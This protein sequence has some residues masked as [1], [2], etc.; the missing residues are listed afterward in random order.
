MEFV[1]TPYQPGETIAAI[2]TPPG[3]GGIAIIRISGDEALEIADKVFTG[4]V[5]TYKTH[6]AHLGKVI[7]SNGDTIDEALA[8]VMLGKRSFCGEDTVEI[9]CHGG[10]IVS[11]HVL[12]VTIQA[13]ARAARPGEFSFKA[14]INGKIDLSQAE[15]IQE[16]ISAKNDMAL[17]AA[18]NH[19][20]GKLSKKVA[21]FQSNL[22]DIAAML[23]AW[24]DFPEE[25]IAF[26][27]M[28][29][30]RNDLT[31]TR[32][33]M[34]E[35][36][37]S[38][39]DGKILHD[40]VTLCLV[41]CPNVGKSSL[42][43]ALLDKDR[44]IVTHIP[45]TTRDVL[46]DSLRLNGLN[47]RL[48]DTAGIREATEI[49]EIE[50]IKRSKKAIEEADLILFVL[51]SKKGLQKD[52]IALCETLPP[53][54]SIAIWNK[55]DLPHENLP[56][57]TFQHTV[58]ISALEKTGLQNLHQSIDKIIWDHGPPSKEELI[59]TNIRHKEA[60]S[61][62][63]ESCDNVINGLATNVSPEFL[64]M[65]MRQCLSELGKIIGTNI[66]EDILSSIFSSFCIG[67]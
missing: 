57:I 44:A 11:R 64:S 60:L 7:N 1:H 15:A 28:E 38:F 46:E 18:E 14:F 12:E 33:M 13:G 48:I 56:E 3:E 8:L 63:I 65:D 53:E 20:E 26:S 5:K 10:S 66:T 55:M 16:L 45:G 6:T 23:E 4:P 52:D 30:V 24:V 35:L 42:M 31:H 43:N 50:G 19:L 61:K 40:G 32:N 27:P 29:K 47:L 58:K 36:E 34:Q 62:A 2:A 37:A 49:V 67:K 51:D 59:I 9:H 54:K 25:D 17:H 22:F 41:G 39:H 21:S